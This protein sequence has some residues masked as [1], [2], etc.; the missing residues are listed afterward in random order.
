MEF[1]EQVE[2]LK[3]LTVTK[4]RTYL[5]WTNTEKGR[6][7]TDCYERID[8][9]FIVYVNTN[10]PSKYISRGDKFFETLEELYSKALKKR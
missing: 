2:N 8:G 4:P 9:S 7:K 3:I 1:K 5:K 6:D 10:N